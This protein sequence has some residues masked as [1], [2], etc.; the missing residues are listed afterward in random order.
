M[1]IQPSES[2]RHRSAAPGRSGPSLPENEATRL[3]AESFR[4]Y[5]CGAQPEARRYCGQALA[6]TPRNPDA[7]HLLGLIAH[8]EGR[9]EEAA[10]LM[11]E[12]IRCAPQNAEYYNNLGI[13][14][15][16]LKSFAKAAVCHRR[17]FELKP[18]LP[19]AA[20]NLSAVLRLVGR[21][22]EAVVWAQ[23][24]IDLDP[25]P[26]GPR[27][28]LALA[29]QAQG[30][31][32]EAIESY[33]ELIRRHPDHA[34]GLFNL[35]VALFDLG[36]VEE[37]SEAYEHA[38]AIR[39]GYPD[40]LNGLAV[41][42][43]IQGKFDE[44]VALCR[45]AIHHREDFPEAVSH[46]A[47]LSQATCAWDELAV[48]K[49]RLLRLNERLLA[50]GAKTA[51]Q[52]MFSL[53][54]GRPP[55]IQRA[56]AESWCRGMATVPTARRRGLHTDRL[57]IGYVSSDFRNH[58]VGH[59]MLGVLRCHSRQKFSVSAYSIGPDDGSPYRRDIEACC[60]RFVDLTECTDAAAAEQIVAD[61]IDILVDL[62]GHTAGNRIGIFALRPAPIQV[63][64]LGYPG[65]TGSGFHDYIVS[66]R[67]VTPPDQQR[68]YTEKF[69]TLP[70]CYM[71]TDDTQ[72]ISRANFQRA[73]FG[74]R[75]DQFVFCSFNDFW[76]IDSVIF[77]VWMALLRE[78][79]SGVLWLR[80]GNSAAARNLLREAMRRG[81]GAERLV[82]AE[83]L[84]FK[85]N[86]LARLAL[87]D[88]VLDTRIY[89][90]HVSTCDALWAGVP[91][92][93][94]LGTTYASRASASMLQ[95][96]GLSELVAGNL[97]A[98]RQTALSLAE[99]DSG[100]KALR[101]RLSRNDREAPLFDSKRFTANLE[102]AYR[103]MAVHHLAGNPPGP[104]DI[105][106]P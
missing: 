74:L 31:L 77:D 1:Y 67:I 28:N 19:G 80:G 70:H 25:D 7:L 79:P 57:R 15:R 10:G 24:A 98:Y 104:M 11:A 85:A 87:A 38:L 12:A 9:L 23:K 20:E 39:P 106:D 27:F 14:L 63:S 103:A 102:K 2:N 88:L 65:T 53:W 18:G 21:F 52:P 100:L 83:K 64:Y 44:A 58:P 71:A 91:V 22:P 72:V 8:A 69:V 54:C 32:R 60:E 59:Q 49:D 78:L 30:L 56:V 62:N 51:E 37:A 68:H 55:E 35:G 40:A 17:A 89:N 36:R 43:R 95:S 33:R 34:A 105:H 81:V 76:K 92:L 73:C 4:C 90:G 84:K 16:E 75:E 45:R 26:P 101:D 48:L 82:F 41:V 13:V 86:H 6:A 50:A 94:L 93:T 61:E 5:R 29:F 42:R 66:D 3:L 47:V 99:Q 46:M 97:E 96:V